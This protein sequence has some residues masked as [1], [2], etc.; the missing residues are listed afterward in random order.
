MTAW[1]Y[2]RFFKDIYDGVDYDS[3]EAVGGI[4]HEQSGHVM[5]LLHSHRIPNIIEGSKIYGISVPTEHVDRA[6]KLVSDDAAKNGYWFEA[7]AD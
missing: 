2:D 4:S 5:K 3:F 7:V 6:I 1:L